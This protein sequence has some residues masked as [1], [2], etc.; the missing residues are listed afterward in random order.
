MKIPL[1]IFKALLRYLQTFSIAIEKSGV[2]LITDSLC[3]IPPSPA[4]F[5]SIYDPL[6]FFLIPGVLT[7]L[8]KYFG[9]S[10]CSVLR[11][12]WGLID[13]ETHI[14]LVQ[15][16]FLQSSCWGKS[17]AAT[18]LG[19]TSKGSPGGIEFIIQF[20]D[21]RISPQFL[22]WY[23]VTILT[24]ARVQSLFGGLSRVNFSSDFSA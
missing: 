4:P 6:F 11:H 23:L 21:S 13:L 3:P 9:I 16:Y 7:F 20:V 5:G 24:Y 17:L 19:A 12:F 14:F 15:R 1:G 18:V 22:A 10:L 8:L 2:V